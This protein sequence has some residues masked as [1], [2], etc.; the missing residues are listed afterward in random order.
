MNEFIRYLLLS[1]ACI[2]ALYLA[3]QLFLRRDTFFMMNRVYL[4]SAAVLS[5]I[6]PLFPFRFSFGGTLDPVI[7]LLE[8]VLITPGNISE[9]TQG[10]LEWFG[11]LT[12]IYF[13]GVAIFGLRFLV[14]LVQLLLLVRRNGITHRDGLNLVLVDRGYSPFSF[15]HFI[16]IK[17]DQLGNDRLSAVIEH[18]K[19]HMRQLHSADLVA[20]ELLT[21]IQWFNPFAWLL[22]R[23]VKAV[24]EYLA[25]EGV[26]RKGVSGSD[27]SRLIFDQTLG[28]QVNNLTNNFNVSLIK[29][30]IAMISKSRS[31]KTA[32]LKALFALPVLLPV[33][34]LFSDGPGN[35]AFPQEKQIAQQQEKVSSPQSGT[36]HKEVA[37]MP[38][39]PGGMDAMVAFL[40]KNM[41]YPE[42][43]KK[44][45]VTGVVYVNF[46]V[47]TDGSI[48]HVK[49]TRGIGSG[50]DEEAVRVVSLMPKWKPGSEKD[51]KPLRVAFTLPIKFSLDGKKK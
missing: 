40:V 43:A 5:M 7:V 18:E 19:V 1:A 38:Q 47:E 28:I 39:Y 4:I 26:L 10:N 41:Q 24:H 48:S 32:R 34:F 8:P 37:N 33:I 17:K 14:Q 9:A 23:S 3:Y 22:Q 45:T 44:D 2:T 49:I 29:K 13:T 27:Y 42:K 12:V 31:A 25:D 11:I 15:F 16:F 20:T 21:I 50:C 46:I 35:P 6:M 51:G 30:R 36:V